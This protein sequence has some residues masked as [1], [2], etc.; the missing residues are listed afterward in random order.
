MLADSDINRD[1]HM[2][3][4]YYICYIYR[5]FE[6][7]G[8]NY[9]TRAVTQLIVGQVIVHNNT[10]TASNIQDIPVQLVFVTE[11]VTI[12]QFLHCPMFIVPFEHTD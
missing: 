7:N 5:V 12:I 6:I 8:T 3:M 11:Q 10:D 9:T 1:S 2:L 4:I